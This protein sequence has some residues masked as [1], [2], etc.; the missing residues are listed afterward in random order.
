M[1]KLFVIATICALSS[2][3]ADEKQKGSEKKP[4][5]AGMMAPKPGPEARDLR[6]LVGTWTTNDTF[7]KIEGMMPGGE[8]TSTE[9]VTPGPGGYSVIMHIKS[10]S[11]PMPNFRGMGVLTWDANEKAYKMAWVDSMTPGMILE[12]GQKEGNDIVMHGEM[13]MGGKKIK[14]KDVI[15]DRTPT[16]YTLTS[17][18]DDGSGEKKTMTVKATKEEA[19]ATK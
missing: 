16:S 17:Y 15:S 11:G 1:K 13:S 18:M 7:E 19:K 2:F 4:A 8:G 5:G 10:T 14:T 9:T 12:T 3:G 6:V